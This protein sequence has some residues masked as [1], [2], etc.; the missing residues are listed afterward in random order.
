MLAAQAAL[1]YLQGSPALPLP[2]P[3]M[4][5]PT[6]PFRAVSRKAAFEVGGV[7]RNPDLIA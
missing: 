3:G 1:R 4:S 7:Y 6:H 5:P 2:L